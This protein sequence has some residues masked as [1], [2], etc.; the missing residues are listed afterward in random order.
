VV[1]VCKLPDR[2]SPEPD[3]LNQMMTDLLDG[4]PGILDDFPEWVEWTR[5]D[6]AS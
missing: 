6:F 5:G 1:H 2:V 3:D 4:T